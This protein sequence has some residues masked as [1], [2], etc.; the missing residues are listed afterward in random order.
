MFE[1]YIST[2]NCIYWACNKQKNSYNILWDSLAD[3]ENSLY[4]KKKSLFAIN[5]EQLVSLNYWPTA[6]EEH[7]WMTQHSLSLPIEQT[8]LF[9]KL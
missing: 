6:E 3:T 8:L 4:L 1:L 9:Q 5:R 2:T 7:R